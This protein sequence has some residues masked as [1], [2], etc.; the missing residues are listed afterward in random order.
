[1]FTKQMDISVNSC[2][3]SEIMITILITSYAK[4]EEKCQL[5]SIIFCPFIILLSAVV[6]QGSIQS[7]IKPYLYFTFVNLVLF[8]L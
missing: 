6:K 1:M 8:Q 5:V 2:K 4:N 7:H 3:F